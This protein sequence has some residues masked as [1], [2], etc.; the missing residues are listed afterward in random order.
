MG[1]SDARGSFE[2]T[3]ADTAGAVEI[4]E[5]E[6][7]AEDQIARFAADVQFGC[8]G[9]P[10]LWTLS[11]L[12]FNSAVA[13]D[14][15]RINDRSLG[16]TLVDHIGRPVAGASVCMDSVGRSS[17]PLTAEDGTWSV[18][19]PLLSAVNDPDIYLTMFPGAK[20]NWQ[21]G[22]FPEG[23][24]C[25]QTK[26]HVGGIVMVNTGIDIELNLGCV[27]SE[28]TIIGTE[29]AETITGTDGADV[30]VGLGG[31]DTIF[32]LGGDDIICAGNGLATVYAGDGNDVLIGGIHADNLRGQSGD[33][34]V[35]GNAGDDV[36]RG[37]AGDDVMRGDV[38]N[39]DMNG[40]RDDDS[41][42]G[43]SGNDFMRG[44]TGD[45]TM[46]G[47]SGNDAVNGNGGSDVVIGDDGDDRVT[48]GPRPDLLWG[49]CPDTSLTCSGDDELRGFGGADEIWGGPGDDLLFGGKQPDRL[50]GGVGIDTCT[51]GTTGITD[52]GGETPAVENDLAQTC[53]SEISIE[54]PLEEPPSGLA[55]LG[56][57]KA[58]APLLDGVPR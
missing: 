38:G 48:G 51:G 16:G 42:V 22:C 35:W 29:G 40:G 8:L 28:A 47:G 24:G 37:N 57:R 9:R 5:L 32:G 49:D 20:T 18:E 26:L 50:I 41:M 2:A 45:D 56:R 3:C 25:G 11:A 46:S 7:D 27:W 14:S 19:L 58:L 12:R 53:E 54:G 36:L 6:L 15:D 21:T 39:D 1:R 4:L 55:A 43:G 23:D 10:E 34:L 30:I 17:C 44:S 33:D 31:G 13:L 52:T